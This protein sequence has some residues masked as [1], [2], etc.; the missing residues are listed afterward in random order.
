M[1]KNRKET[2][3]GENTIVDFRVGIPEPE[4]EWFGMVLSYSCSLG[5]YV[6]YSAINKTVNTLL[7]LVISVKATFGK[8]FN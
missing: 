4:S 8:V 1:T 6:S 3:N 5:V 2:G 7:I